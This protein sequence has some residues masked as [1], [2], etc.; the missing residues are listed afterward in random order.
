[1][2]QKGWKSSTLMTWLSF[3]AR[4]GGLLLVTPLVLKNFSPAQTSL[5]FLFLTIASLLMMADFGFGPSFVRAISYARGGR[6]HL[7]SGED[8]LPG[9]NLPLLG[10]IYRG[11]LA[12]YTRLTLIGGVLGAGLGSWAIAKPISQLSD[13]KEGWM[14]WGIVF[15]ASLVIFRNNSYS[16]WMQGLNL[17]AHV[18]RAEAILALGTTRLTAGMI[19]LTRS[20][21]WS[22]LAAQTGSLLSSLVIR[23]LGRT[24]Q[25]V[26]EATDPDAERRVMAFIWPAAWRSGVGVLMSNAVIQASGVVYAQMA[27]P[28]QVAPYLLAMRIIS[29]I[30]QISMAPFYS[31][32]PHFATLYA[33]DRRQELI[34]DVQR[35][36][37]RAHWVYVAGILGVALL[38]TPLLH[39]I[40][41]KVNFVSID[42]W[43]LMGLAFFLERMGAMHMQ[44]Y[45]LSNHILW[46]IANAVAGSIYLI[47]AIILAPQI[48]IWAFPLGIVAGYAGFYTWYSMRLSYHHYGINPFRFELKASFLPAAIYSI[49]LC[50]AYINYWS[51]QNHLN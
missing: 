8:L 45:S 2:L 1:L 34:G 15:C 4:S 26:P 29:M 23:Y 5:W 47:T 22:V 32:I 13:T 17:V 9:P 31:K 49:S 24:A 14:A 19:F 48:G 12:S 20:F 10:A 44:F 39:L 30:T 3:A 46:H 27:T 6:R 35:A 7:E 11:L 43:L 33:A 25:G 51:F 42:L 40:G 16:N 50:V 36:M 28:S 41:S 21:L 38:A 18:R 37:A